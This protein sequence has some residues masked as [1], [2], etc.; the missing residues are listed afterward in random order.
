MANVGG[1][2]L[3]LYALFLSDICT[4]SLEKDY[5]TVTVKLLDSCV[6]TR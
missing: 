2:G 1:M 6:S 5:W 4:C 3:Q